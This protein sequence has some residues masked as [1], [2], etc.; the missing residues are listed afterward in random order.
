MA[1]KARHAFGQ[2]ENIDSA[3][4]ANKIDAYDILFVKDADGKPYV[5]WI[6]KDGN[7]VIVDDTAEL[8]EL[9]NQ[10]AKKANAEDVETLEGQI[11]TKADS[12]DVVALE[13]ELATKTNAEEVDSKIKAA[14]GEIECA[15]ETYEKVK[16]EIADAPAGTL[17][18]MSENE[19]RIMCP[20]NSVWTKQNV[21]AG[22]DSNCYYCTFKTYVY[23]DSIVGYVEH[24]NGQI[25][26]QVLT[27]LKT[28]E[29]GRRYQPT[30]LALAKYDEV[31]GAWS[32]Y[33]VNSNENK[34][35]GYDYQIDWYNANG[36]MVAS[37]SIRINLSNENCH[38]AVE[39]YYVGSMMAKVDEKIA[40]ATAGA[41]EVVEF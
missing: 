19:I 9:E 5:G 3:I 26:S 40:E 20:A 31:T 2:L 13:K 25:D 21:G 36:V 4:A 35:I 11:A 41:I 18:K 22:G 16:Y 39:P 1:D 12:E 37:D 30:W 6:D 33:G 15:P 27:D 14:L 34:M 38:F 29:Y 24:L 28:D 10:I 8:L 17:V 23:D 32:Y 7:K